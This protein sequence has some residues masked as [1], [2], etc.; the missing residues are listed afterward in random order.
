M[1]TPSALIASALRSVGA[2]A[3][4]ETADAASANDAFDL[5]NDMLSQLS[6]ERMLIA[7]QSELIFPLVSGTGSYTFGQAGTA[8]ATVTGSISGFTLTV[9]AITSGALVLGQT[10]AGAGV[11]AGTTITSFGT[12]SGG[13]GTYTVGT[14]QTVGSV[15]LTASY[16]RPIRINNAFI[17]SSNIDYWCEPVNEQDYADIG[18]KSLQAGPWLRAVYYKPSAP[19]AVATF[20]PVPSGG[21]AHFFADTQLLR[22]STL[23]DSITLPAAANDLLRY[24][25]AKRLLIEF[26]RADQGMAA[27]IMEQYA[28]AKAAVK[29]MNTPPQ[30]MMRIDAA[31]QGG[32]NRDPSYIYRGGY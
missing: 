12:G 7:Y 22:F 13:V 5:L 3:S 28:L 20:Y 10:L 32:Q 19:L 14:S 21:E 16:A 25:L 1:T 15:T 27:L 31:L 24:G 4:G 6:S 18:L 23:A 29:R 17:R 30:Q 11:T 8:A 2:L 9:S 26:G